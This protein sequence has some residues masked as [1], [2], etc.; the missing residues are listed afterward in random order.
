MIFKE[1]KQ[2]ALDCGADLVGFA[3]A[4]QL[5]DPS[6]ARDPQNILPG[7]RTM[8]ILAVR[9][10]SG[11]LKS[12]EIR[13]AVNDCR[14]MDLHLGQIARKIGRQ[15]EDK[16]FTAVPLPSY[17]PLKMDVKTKGLL[18]DVSLKKA[19]AIA[20]LGEIGANQLLVT[21]E[22]GP[23]IRLTGILTDLPFEEADRVET[24]FLDCSS[25]GLCIDKCPGQALSPAGID[26]K[27]CIQH[28]GN[29][30]GLSSL[31]KFILSALDKQ[32]DEVKTMIHSPELW[33]YYQNFMVGT[34]FNCHVCQSV[35]PIGQKHRL[36]RP[37]I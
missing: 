3:D 31:I 27:K 1:I 4:H 24:R 19:G 36:E 15:I 26:I 35:C 32:K 22:F 17:Y 30:Y 13:M 18:G 11:T 14:H 37:S 2:A 9:Y 25:C 23:R 16:G 33:N 34:H 20:G 21:P 28:V 12:P 8:I 29:P 7:A 10:L 5:F 6:T